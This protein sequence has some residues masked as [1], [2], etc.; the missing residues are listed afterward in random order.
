MCRLFGL[1][2]NKPVNIR[3]SMLEAGNSFKRQGKGNADGWGIG[4]YEQDGKSKIEKYG[5]SAFASRRFNE[6]AKEVNSKIFIAHVR[7][8]SSGLEKSQRNAHPFAYKSWL[9][10]HNGTLKKEEVL[11]LLSEPYSLGFTSEPI[12]SELYFRYIVQ[13]IEKDKDPIEGIK[14]ATNEVKYLGRGLNFILSDG[15]NL[16]AYRDG[17]PLYYLDRNPEEYIN[18]SSEETEALID[19]KKARNEKAVI[20]ATEKITESENWQS[21]EN[22]KLIWINNDL[23]IKEV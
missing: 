19:I 9:F 8:M 23:I 21:I 18:A 13:C 2:A 20:V 14:R 17:N 11:N 10:A 6:L 22:N 7:Y 12:D 3:F 5:E 1:I 15:K 16:Y 4:W